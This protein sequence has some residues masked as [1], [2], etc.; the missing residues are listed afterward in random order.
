[1]ADHKRKKK[2][3]RSKLFRSCFRSFAPDVGGE[4]PFPKSDNRILKNGRLEKPASDPKRDDFVSEVNVDDHRSVERSSNGRGISRLLKSVLFDSVMVKKIRSSSKSSIASDTSDSFLSIEKTSNVSGKE[5][6]DIERL[7]SRCSNLLSS[8]SRTTSS[9]YT[10]SS[11]SSTNSNS[12]WLPE[13]KT[14]SLILSPTGSTNSSS[15]QKQNQIKSR[16]RSFSEQKTSSQTDSI[17]LS[18]QDTSISLPC[19]KTNSISQSSSYINSLSQLD[20][21]KSGSSDNNKSVC[22]KWSVRWCLFPFLSFIV[23]VTYGRIYSI[24]CTSIWLYLLP[25][26]R[27]KQVKLVTNT[28]RVL[29]DTESEQY[30]KRV[31]MAGLLDRTRNQLR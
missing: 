15:L 4:R 22:N 7:S 8:S 10:T 27:V 20:S 30:K 19:P 21:E 5:V 23:L 26:R 25:T 28:V 18:R 2:R 16:S 11:S 6:T 1:M 14:T 12:Q 31:I 24:L 29:D 13:P 9:S 3:G 17:H